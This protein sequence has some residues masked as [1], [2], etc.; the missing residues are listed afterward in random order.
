MS[1]IALKIMLHGLI[2]LVPN[3]STGADHMTALL[4]D[5]RTPND[6][7]CIAEHAPKLV[8]MVQDPGQCF[9]A[10]CKTNGNECTC[11][12]S[13]AGK[14]ITL[15][16]EPAPTPE[17]QP[18]SNDILL[19]LPDNSDEAGLYSNIANLSRSSFSMKLKSQY[20]DSG[21]PTNL[22]PSNLLARMEFPFDRVTA[23]SLAK[24]EDGGVKNIQGVSFRSLHAE[25]QVG[26]TLQPLAQMAVADIKLSSNG[27]DAPKATLKIRGFG[28]DPANAISF[29]LMPKGVTPIYMIELSNDTTPLRPDS[30]CDDG[31]GRHFAFYYDFAENPP[32]WVERLIPHIRPAH[33]RSP[34]F[35][36]PEACKDPTFTLMDRPMCPIASFDHP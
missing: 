31:I 3:K 2:A 17:G 13:L 33:S 8:V 27:T 30:L 23:C 35:L 36:E 29:V 12:D 4:L 9:K 6:F 18:L 34:E 22:P 14:D 5:A 15:E 25:G 1:S 19:R 16:I 24:R 10:G 28:D 26:D 32:T 11:G 20:L 7:E 21:T